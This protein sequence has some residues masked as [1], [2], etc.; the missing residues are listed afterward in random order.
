MLPDPHGALLIRVRLLRQVSAS[1]DRRVPGAGYR[2]T[3][4]YLEIGRVTDTRWVGVH[5][6]VSGPGWWRRPQ[7]G[8]WPAAYR[9]LYTPQT[10]PAEA[11]SSARAGDS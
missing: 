11:T 5:P 6:V 8:H 9:L 10:D 2:V 4:C 7:G 3:G 1:G